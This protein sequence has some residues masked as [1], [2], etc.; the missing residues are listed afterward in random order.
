MRKEGGRTPGTGL[1]PGRSP[2]SP[3]T[4]ATAAGQRSEKQTGSTFAWSE[5]IPDRSA[6]SAITKP[7][8]AKNRWP[9]RARASCQKGQVSW[10]G[11]WRAIGGL[12]GKRKSC[13]QDDEDIAWEGGPPKLLP[14]SVLQA[15]CRDSAQPLN[16]A[17][18]HRV[19]NVGF[20]YPPHSCLQRSAGRV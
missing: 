17:Q 11:G 6:P 7:E 10:T 13:G 9:V 4:A 16:L 18:Q 15:L 12:R 20:C 2:P 5:A 19:W 3:D 14:A 8:A 1:P